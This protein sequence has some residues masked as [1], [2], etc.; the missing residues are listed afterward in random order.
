MVPNP[1]PQR[2]EEHLHS[3]RQQLSRRPAPNQ[4]VPPMH[5]LGA[6]EL[7]IRP[8]SPDNPAGEA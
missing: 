4:G 5:L 1:G 8:E 7:N 3:E 2:I 6:F